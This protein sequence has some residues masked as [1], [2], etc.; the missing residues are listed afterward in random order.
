MLSLKSIGMVLA[1]SGLSVAVAPA[2]AVIP[3]QPAQLCMASNQGQEVMTYQLSRSY[4][5]QCF[6]EEWQL[7]AICDRQGANC[8]AL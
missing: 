1:V 4:L 8:N 3:G 6:A 5:W 7:V 2:H